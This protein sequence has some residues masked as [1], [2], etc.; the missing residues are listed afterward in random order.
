M[1]KGAAC[2][3]HKDVTIAWHSQGKILL[4]YRVPERS[5]GDEVSKILV[6]EG[7]CEHDLYLGADWQPL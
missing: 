3:K 1:V 7:S 4:D 6:H 5:S 2:R